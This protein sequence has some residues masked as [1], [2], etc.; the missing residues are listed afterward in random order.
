M[1]MYFNYS[2]YFTEIFQNK[3]FLKNI[4]EGAFLFF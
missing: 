2:F 1:E 4:R 3:N